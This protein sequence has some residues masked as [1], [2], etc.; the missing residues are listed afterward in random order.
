MKQYVILI[1]FLPF[2]VQKISVFELVASLQ[3]LL[4][5][6]RQ[7]YIAGNAN[8]LW[9]VLVLL[10]VRAD[11]LAVVLA[12]VAPLGVHR[13][14]FNIDVVLCFRMIYE[15]PHSNVFQIVLHK[16]LIHKSRILLIRRRVAEVHQLFALVLD[17]AEFRQQGQLRSLIDLG[18]RCRG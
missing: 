1:V 5:S 9:N 11:H 15:R 8:I 7:V 13:H 3:P 10:D 14:I 17:L 4:V 18:A 16:Q 2:R 12:L 6:G